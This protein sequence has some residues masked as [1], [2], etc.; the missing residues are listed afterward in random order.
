MGKRGSRSRALTDDVLRPKPVEVQRSRYTPWVAFL[1]FV[2]VL[3]NGFCWCAQASAS[4][5]DTQ[6]ACCHEADGASHTPTAPARQPACPHC[7]QH[8]LNAAEPV[9][10]SGIQLAPMLSTLYVP[11]AG[12]LSAFTSLALTHSPVVVTTSPS[13]VRRAKCVLL[14]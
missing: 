11:A 4:A 6:H 2:V 12:P 13:A 3:L 9:S 7:A 5:A 8:R 1:A 14:L 10:A